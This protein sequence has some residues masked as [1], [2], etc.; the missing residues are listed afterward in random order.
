MADK[1]KSDVKQAYFWTKILDKRRASKANARHSS[2]PKAPVS[3]EDKR[4]LIIAG[5]IVIAIPIVFVILTQLSNKPAPATPGTPP[6]ASS[7]N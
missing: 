4:N 7:G 6:A 1:V 2:I 5:A 3:A